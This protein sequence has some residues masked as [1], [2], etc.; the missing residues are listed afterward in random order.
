[1]ILIRHGETAANA[2]HAIDTAPPGAPLSATGRDQAA[3]LVTT[4]ADEPIDAVWSSDLVR[5]QE[6]AAPLAA[7]RGLATQVEPGLREIQAGDYENGEWRPYVTVIRQWAHDPNVRMPG[8]ETGLEFFAR[9]TRAVDRI[10][11][12]GAATA[13]V[14][15][16]G[17]ALRVWLTAALGDRL[18]EDPGSLWFLANTAHVVLEN[19]TGRWLVE[20]WTTEYLVDSHLDEA[21]VESA[22]TAHTTAG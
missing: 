21:D 8:A 22:I 12:S 19:S 7:A 16:H 10:A 4:L 18:P 1:L 2:S 3:R 5:A 13:A 11:A 17:G 9:F 14:V 15:S 6:T 20:R